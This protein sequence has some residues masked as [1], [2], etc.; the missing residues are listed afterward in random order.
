MKNSIIIAVVF[1]FSI[2]LYLF[3]NNLIE[4]YWNISG[5]K[6]KNAYL[7]QQVKQN[8]DIVNY[9]PHG[10]TI[11][12][13]NKTLE[14]FNYNPSD[15]KEQFLSPEEQFN[16]IEQ[17]KMQSNNSPIFEETYYNTRSP[18]NLPKHNLSDTHIPVRENYMEARGVSTSK[19]TPFGYRN[20]A[21]PE[22]G[23]GLLRG[24]VPIREDYSSGSMPQFGS[25]KY[26]AGNIQKRGGKEIA[27]ARGEISINPQFQAGQRMNLANKDSAS[28]MVKRERLLKQM[29][30][31][32]AKYFGVSAQPSPTAQENYTAGIPRRVRDS[33]LYEDFVVGM[34]RKVRDSHNSNYIQSQTKPPQQY[35]S[36]TNINQQYEQDEGLP[37]VDQQF[38]LPMVDQQ[39][40][41]PMVDQQYEEPENQVGITV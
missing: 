33:R 35:I 36:D 18:Q 21:K 4:G 27:N 5:S 13:E 1:L 2:C 39:F 7:P 41:L 19:V 20:G 10:T 8:M 16:N 23:A 24:E 14:T 37:M 34:P 40:E 32:A 12:N 15:V 38:E 31:E 9:K 3:N 26:P 22:F 30:P 29:N 28:E 11:E 17:F 25:Y 6:V